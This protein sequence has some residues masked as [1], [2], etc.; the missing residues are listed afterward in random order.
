MADRL[1]AHIPT[2]R[3]AGPRT[4]G[5]P[6]LR[7]GPRQAR[8]TMRRRFR[9]RIA[10]I[11]PRLLVAQE[12]RLRLPAIVLLSGCV[13]LLAFF[14]TSDLFYVG[15]VTV[16]GQS[17]VSAEEIRRAA[18]ADNYNVFYLNFGQL[19]QRVLGVPGI[20]D[21]TV[22]YEP[23]NSLRLSVLERTPLLTWESGKRT[24][25]VD[26]SGT[27]F[28]IGKAPS[29]LPIVRDSEGKARQ[30]LDPKLVSGM[31]VL[32]TALPGLRRADYADMR[33]LTFDDERG[34]KILFG[35]PEQI[36]AKLA[37]LNALVTYLNA[38]KIEPEYVDVRQPERAY[39]K[40]K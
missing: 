37:M 32:F 16:E 35:A 19:Q 17:L 9:S 24:A 26:D 21:A 39:Y 29:G 7:S 5:S 27:I 34:W 8:Q 25:W 14:S 6:R 31:L 23:P 2:S 28:T 18:G 3:R 33:G 22:S 13:A 15:Q 20:R 30:R 10:S 36:N 40:P 4:P 11:K 1:E 38:Q 12:P